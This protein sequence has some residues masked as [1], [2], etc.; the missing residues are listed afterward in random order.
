MSAEHLNDPRGPG[1]PRPP[2][3]DA[4]PVMNATPARQ[5]R[6]DNRVRFILGIGLVLVVVAFVAVYFGTPTSSTP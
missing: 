5:G 4:A 2:V 1:D 3:H 6:S